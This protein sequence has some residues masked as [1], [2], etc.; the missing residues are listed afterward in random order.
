MSIR[1]KF[2]YDITS[3][4]KGDWLNNRILYLFSWLA[5]TLLQ[6]G[7][8]CKIFTSFSY[9]FSNVFRDWSFSLFV[10]LVSVFT[11]KVFIYIF[12]IVLLILKFLNVF[13]NLFRT[14]FY[15]F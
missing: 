3:L 14:G 2:Y 4:Y 13:M 8:H 9:L 7:T 15:E 10:F 12:I 6:N 11:I 5:F 1:A